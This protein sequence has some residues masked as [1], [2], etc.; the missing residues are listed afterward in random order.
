MPSPC[1]APERLADLH[2]RLRGHRGQRNPQYLPPPSRATSARA[3]ANGP[4]ARQ[5][6]LSRE[7]APSVP[8]F[9]TWSSIPPP[10]ITPTTP[11]ERGKG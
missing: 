7:K 9:P 10:A 1:L 8:G 4:A 5:L 11:V 3:A 2:V 6:A